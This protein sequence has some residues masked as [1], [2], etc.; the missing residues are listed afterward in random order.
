MSL[1][2]FWCSGTTKTNV[3]PD[4][5]KM[6]SL[7]WGDCLTHYLAI[8]LIVSLSVGGF[9]TITSGKKKKRTSNDED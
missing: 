7:D 4:F 8:S 2:W 1:S 3:S 9:L 6:K 5:T